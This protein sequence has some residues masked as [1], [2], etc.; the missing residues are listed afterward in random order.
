VATGSATLS[1]IGGGLAVAATA[2]GGWNG[3]RYARGYI[4]CSQTVTVPG[5]WVWKCPGGWQCL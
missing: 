1:A 4:E 2:I 5:K 3:G